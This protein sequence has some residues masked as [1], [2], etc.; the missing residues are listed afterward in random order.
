MQRTPDS[1]RRFS[2]NW[3]FV[4]TQGCKWNWNSLAKFLAKIFLLLHFNIMIL[5][6]AW[7]GS[8][9]R[10]GLGLQLWS[11]PEV[12][13][14]LFICFAAFAPLFVR[15]RTEIKKSLGEFLFWQE[16]YRQLGSWKRK[17]ISLGNNFTY[18]LD[19]FIGLISLDTDSWAWNCHHREIETNVKTIYSAVQ[20][21]GKIAL[22]P[23]LWSQSILTSAIFDQNRNFR[24]LYEKRK[25]R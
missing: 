16:L 24:K 10:V 2:S 13:G 5:T 20:E 18:F 9:S 3:K 14:D 7:A 23:T 11:G 12:L 15:A 17:K 8:T 25:R 6:A 22:F 19:L 4:W 1:A 21:K